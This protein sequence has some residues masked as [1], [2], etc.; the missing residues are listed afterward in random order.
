MSAFGR[1]SGAGGMSKGARPS[2]GVAKPMRGVSPGGGAKPAPESEAV[3]S[4]G[5]EQ[6]PPV[7]PESISK[8]TS[9]QRTQTSDNKSGHEEPVTSSSKQVLRIPNTRGAA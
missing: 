9:Q 5:G 3:P 1:K 6:F 7:P 8:P 4:P 2:F